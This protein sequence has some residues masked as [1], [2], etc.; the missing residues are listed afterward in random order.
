MKLLIVEPIRK[1]R[2]RRS[3]DKNFPPASPAVLSFERRVG[4]NNI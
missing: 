2:G 1:V 3:M 4:S